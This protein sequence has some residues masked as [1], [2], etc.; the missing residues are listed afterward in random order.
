MLFHHEGASPF[1]RPIT[2]CFPRHDRRSAAVEGSSHFS[3]KA[4]GTG[5]SVDSGA[6]ISG[7]APGVNAGPKTRFAG[8]DRKR[9][10]A[11]ADAFVSEARQ[12]RCAL[13]HR[14]VPRLG[15]FQAR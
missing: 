9:P 10:C 13:W 14:F 12:F 4:R 7:D 11:L 3:E 2:N 1:A 15:G 8:K 5:L 6:E